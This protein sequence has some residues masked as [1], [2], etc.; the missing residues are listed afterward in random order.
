L[1]I[2]VGNFDTLLDKI[3]QYFVYRYFEIKHQNGQ[4]VYLC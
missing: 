2:F 1:K 4:Y 3:L